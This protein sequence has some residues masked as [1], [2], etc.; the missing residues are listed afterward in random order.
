MLGV[1]SLSS[2][3]LHIQINLVY[4]TPPTNN[5]TSHLFVS[6]VLPYKYT[7]LSVPLF[8]YINIQFW[9]LI[10]NA[11][12]L[13]FPVL[14]SICTSQLSWK[15]HY[16]QNWQCSS[17]NGKTQSWTS[18]NLLCLLITSIPFPSCFLF[19]N[20]WI[21]K[22]PHLLVTCLFCQILIIIFLLHTC[23]YIQMQNTYNPVV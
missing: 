10:S 15:Q 20:I 12:P 22:K 2:L 23:T 3:F 17:I 16:P 11:C 14:H 13:C 21:H 4:F 6:S 7:Y 8:H 18:V 5:L 1:P 19:W 9:Q